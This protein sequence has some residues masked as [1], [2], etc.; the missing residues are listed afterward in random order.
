MGLAD[1]EERYQVSSTFTFTSYTFWL[2]KVT[3][4]YAVAASHEA[5]TVCIATGNVGVRESTQLLYSV[6]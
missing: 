5:G 2:K 3:A 6:A 1:K 4:A